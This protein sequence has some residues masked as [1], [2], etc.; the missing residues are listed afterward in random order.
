MQVAF[1]S[2][3]SLT[4]Y[5]AYSSKGKTPIDGPIDQTV[6]VPV[7]KKPLSLTHPELA[8]E[9]DGWDPSKVA[10]GSNRKLEWKCKEKHQWLAS[11]D[12]R[13]GRGDGCP[14]CSGRRVLVGFNDLA[15]THLDLAKEAD[16]WD[17]STVTQGSHGDV[18]WRCSSGHK[19][20][21]KVSSRGQGHGCPICS[22]NQILVGFNDLATTHL[23]IAKEADGWDPRTVSKG[24]TKKMKWKCEQDHHWET[25]VFTRTDGSGCPVCAGKQILIGFNDLATTRPELANEA[26]GWDPRTVT[27]GSNIKANWLC[28]KGHRWKS[29]IAD[30]S[31][32]FGC[33]ICS[34]KKVL[35]GFN[36]FATTHPKLAKET[37]GWE[38][39][40]VI[41][42]FG[43][44]FDWKCEKGHTW[45]ATI[46]SRTAGNGCAICSGK[47]VLVGFNDLATL[48]P[49]LASE[50]EGWDPTT[51]TQSSGLKKLWKCKEAHVWKSLVASRTDGHGCP[52]CAGLQVLVG[53]NDLATT[54]PELA[55]EADGWDPQTVIR[56]SGKKRPWLCSN[57]HRW[58]APISDRS[59]GHGCPTCAKFGFDP[60]LDG[61]LYFLEHPDWELLQIGIT[62]HPDER[63][64][65]HGK[66]GWNV[67]E[68]RGSMDGL[69]A[70]GWE[71][72]ILQMLKRRKAKFASSD[73]AG[74]FNGYTESWIKGSFPVSSL[75]EMIAFVRQDEEE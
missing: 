57:G 54:H 36:D 7:L 10:A 28:I 4:S 39:A 32:G 25:P 49:H 29:R 65:F 5:V 52:I 60:N 31:N 40:T 47:Q 48:Q 11:V 8:K 73:I 18:N 34:N 42:G 69:I 41:K 72:S 51:V 12:K 56:G 17:P 45:H 55:N 23:E 13:S 19:W 74:K 61:W 14:Y 67:I 66:F 27:Q 37:D 68:I 3:F 9:A 58:I 35:S 26:D 1:G 15:T 50:A 2:P 59:S 6:A 62:N 53:F 38:P 63:L 30:R 16:G 64:K 20:N 70:R 33:P 21:A 22:G 44:K 24:S 75:S 71:T 43:V 46:D